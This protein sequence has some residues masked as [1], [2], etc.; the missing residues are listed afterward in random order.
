MKP[1]WP[2]DE[3]LSSMLETEPLT[4]V[5][6][7][8]GVSD[9]AVH[10]RCRKRSIPTKPQGYWASLTASPPPVRRE[11]I[12]A[13]HGAKRQKNKAWLDEMRR[14]PCLRCARSFP[15]VCMDWHHRD[16]STK[17]FTIRRKISRAKHI[18]LAE[19]AKCDLVCSNCHRIIEAEENGR[20]FE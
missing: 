1:N 7:K 19:I 13:L 4:K 6:K 17:L 20:V 11:K 3:D 5:A 18:L 15:V 2:S 8:I 12:R 9:V 16:K 14:S 10:Q